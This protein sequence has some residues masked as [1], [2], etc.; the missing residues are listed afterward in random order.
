M[1]VSAG[2]VLMGCVLVR[3]GKGRK[4]R[5][6]FAGPK[7]RQA[8]AHYLR[9]RDAD[10][11][12]AAPHR[13]RTTCHNPAPRQ[14]RKSARAQRARLSQSLCLGKPA[15]GRGLVSLQR[16]VGHS[17][18]SVMRRYLAQSEGDLQASHDQASPVDS[19]L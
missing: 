10:E 7:T 6:T 17:D 11:G 18:L 16:F 4:P 1:G 12:A 14:E 8:I 15:D 2:T 19:L 13:D 9:Q 5:V 3:S